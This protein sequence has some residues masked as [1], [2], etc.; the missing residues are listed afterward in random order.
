MKCYH[1]F[2]YLVL[3]AAMNHHTIIPASAET[4]QDRME[5]EHTQLVQV[6]CIDGIISNLSLKILIT[7]FDFFKTMYETAP[8][9]TFFKCPY[10]KEMVRFL[11]LFAL[12]DKIL[13]IQELEK[14]LPPSTNLDIF[15]L[16]KTAHN[17]GF[18]RKTYLSTIISKQFNVY[19]SAEQENALL[20]GDRNLIDELSLLES[21]QYEDIVPPH[22]HI[23]GD[24]WTII[25]LPDEQEKYVCHSA[26][27]KKYLT[28]NNVTRQLKLYS[29]PY[30]LLITTIQAHSPINYATLNS[31]GRYIIFSSAS[32]LIIWDTTSNTEINRDIIPAAITDITF[33]R[34]GDTAAITL[35]SQQLFLWN[36]SSNDSKCWLVPTHGPGT[37]NPAFSPDG[38]YL[39]WTFNNASYH[40]DLTTS[41][42]CT[43]SLPDIKIKNVLSFSPDGNYILYSTDQGLI[44]SK[45]IPNKSMF[46]TT[47]IKSLSEEQKHIFFHPQKNFFLFIVDGHL[48]SFDLS[49]RKRCQYEISE[50]LTIKKCIWSPSGTM[51]ALLC[52]KAFLICSILSYEDSQMDIEILIKKDYQAE[53]ATFSPDETIITLSALKIILQIDIASKKVIADFFLKHSITSI[54]WTPDGEAL[55]VECETQPVSFVKFFLTPE[56][57]RPWCS[58]LQRQLLQTVHA[59]REA[60]YASITV[61]P[62]IMQLFEKIPP[63]HRSLVTATDSHELVFT[64]PCLIPDRN[65]QCPICFENLNIEE[66]EGNVLGAPRTVDCPSNHEFHSL[67]IA[68]ALHADHDTCPVCRCKIPD[69]VFDT[70]TIDD[71]FVE[72]E[73]CIRKNPTITIPENS[74]QTT[75]LSSKFEE[76]FSKLPYRMKDQ[77]RELTKQLLHHPMTKQEAECLESKQ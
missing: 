65:A 61:A 45:I 12:S 56:N 44:A 58:A 43:Y 6:A 22:V 21:R 77:L 64:K 76:S 63:K 20:Q 48:Q 67:C 34:D 62:E 29:L 52:D 27:Y 69:Q 60:G 36:R 2:R 16:I 33:S 30:N 23:K 35:A 73:L 28:Y 71:F 18:K 3:I 50:N 14:Q 17:L 51:L 38:T 7:H 53:A 8:D 9:T 4:S 15:L 26:N 75:I 72:S 11:Y 10:P 41:R 42:L 37:N 32:T 68:K 39:T 1:F 24:A 19:F 66:I 54:Q 46:E 49:T 47:T 40:L 13:L 55:L 59:R 5:Q 70:H 57:Y 31:N 25:T 74:D